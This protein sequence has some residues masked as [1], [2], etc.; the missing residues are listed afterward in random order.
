MRMYVELYCNRQ[1]FVFVSNNSLYVESLNLNRGIFS[2][3]FHV[4]SN[5]NFRH[6]QEQLSIYYPTISKPKNPMRNFILNILVCL[7]HFK[8][9]RI[10]ILLC[11]YDEEKSF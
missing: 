4:L 2:N 10:H 5:K 8:P 11:V 9:F 1:T 6:R 3:L 7:I